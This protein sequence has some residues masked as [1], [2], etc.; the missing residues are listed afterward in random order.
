MSRGKRLPEM[1]IGSHGRVVGFHG[2]ERAWLRL[3]EMG[4]LEGTRICLVRRAPLGDPLE[5]SLRGFHLS[6][7][8]SEASC[9]EVEEDS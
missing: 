7:R 3:M 2:E 1:K 9:I 4:I 6:L 5:V 8:A